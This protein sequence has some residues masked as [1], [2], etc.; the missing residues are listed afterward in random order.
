MK[1]NIINVTMRKAI[2]YAINYT[3]IIEKIGQNRAVRSKSCI[4]EYM[5]YSNTTAF[6]MPYYNISKARQ[7]LIDEGWPGTAGLTANDNISMGNEWEVRAINGPPLA[8]YNH[9]YFDF[10]PTQNLSANLLYENLKQI[11]V[12][13]TLRG[14]LG[15]WFAKQDIYVSN[16]F[17]DYLDPGVYSNWELAVDTEYIQ[18]TDT[19]STQW[20]EEALGV[21]N[22]T[23]RKQLYF[24]IQ[25]RIIEDVYPMIWT[26]NWKKIYISVSNLKGLQYHPF[27]F[28]LK[29]VYFD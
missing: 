14:D 12:N 18:F 19:N 9:S 4:P 6:N 28:L 15:P 2:S 7:V 5:F 22:E 23:A 24:K 16:F 17:P 29:T 11:G 21:L 20:M 10:I 8:T 3:Y 27:K 13:L 1:N 26:M 25:K